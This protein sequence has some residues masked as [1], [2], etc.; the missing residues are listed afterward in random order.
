MNIFE[1]N[2]ECILERPGFGASSGNRLK[3]DALD[4]VLRRRNDLHRF[5]AVY[6]RVPDGDVLEACKT[7]HAGYPLGIDVEFIVHVHDYQWTWTDAQVFRRYIFNIAG[8]AWGA[9]KIERA[10]SL[11]KR[12]MLH[13]D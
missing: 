6:L 7:V 4:A 3:R 1:L 8:A 10:A 13:V 5:F 2:F 11:L 9:L 12:T